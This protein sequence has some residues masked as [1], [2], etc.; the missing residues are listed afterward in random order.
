MAIATGTKIVPLVS[1]GTCGPL[2]VLHLPRLWSKITLDAV[3][4][5]PE[6]YDVIGPGFDSMTLSA[7]GLDKNEVQTYIKTKKPTYPQFEQWVLQKKGGKLD[8]AV[9]KKHNDAVL[10]YN[11]DNEK[12]KHMREDMGVTHSTCADAVTLNTLDDLHEFYQTIYA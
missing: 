10:G 2:G 12:A 1:S 9:V 5:L 7:L 11:H 6:G 3:G 8:P 4:A